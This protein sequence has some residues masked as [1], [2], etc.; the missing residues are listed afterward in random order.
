MNKE[1]NVPDS[2]ESRI[3]QAS[4][5]LGKTPQEVSSIL[6]TYGVEELPVGLEMLSDDTATPFG[7]LRK[8]FCDDNGIALP[9]LRMAMKYLRGPVDSPKTD[10]VTTEEY[11]LRNKYDIKGNWDDLPTEQ[12]LQSYNPAQKDSPINRTL[13]KRF[14]ERA[15]IAFKPE[16]R[17]VA[18]DETINYISDLEDG[19][20]DEEF[21]EVDGV[22]VKLYPIN[23]VP[24]QVIEEDPLFPNKPLKR[25]RSIINRLDWNGVSLETRQFFRIL[26]DNNLLDLQVLDRVTIRNII[27][28]PKASLEELRKTYPEAA[29]MFAELKKRDQLPKLKLTLDDVNDNKA[30]NPFNVRTYR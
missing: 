19:F 25:G 30:Q 1:T 24:N 26:I 12:L 20:P 9:K 10:S 22:P 16:S 3:Q 11:D 23:K 8:V 21:V 28:G 17:D 15:I 13:K 18:I 27:S 29:I 4:I 5:I 14:G 7:D 2:W 6:Q